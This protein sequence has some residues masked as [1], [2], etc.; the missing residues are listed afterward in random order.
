MMKEITK[1]KLI[2]MILKNESYHH[3]HEDIAHEL[4]QITK[5]DE[6]QH[7]RNLYR[8]ELMRPH[9]KNETRMQY[10]PYK[11]KGSRIEDE[12]AEFRTPDEK[13]VSA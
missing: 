12:F 9:S 6:A 2:E 7:T 4:G 3:L 5:T 1:E 8:A 11:F 13:A 10:T